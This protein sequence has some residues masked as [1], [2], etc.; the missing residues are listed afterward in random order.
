MRY[1]LLYIMC[2]FFPLLFVSCSDDADMEEYTPKAIAF[3][4]FMDRSEE[5]TRSVI[6]ED[7]SELINH[8]AGGNFWMKAYLRESSALYIDSRVWYNADYAAE[9]PDGNHWQF[10]EGDDQTGQI[11]NVYWPKDKVLDF[12]AYMPYNYEDYNK[13]DQNGEYTYKVTPGYDEQNHGV[14]IGYKMPK[15]FVEDDDHQEFIYAFTPDKSGATVSDGKINV[16]FVHPL[17]LIRFKLAKDS[18]R[19]KINN[20]SL[21]NVHTEGRFKS[22]QNTNEGMSGTWDLTPEDN[23]TPAKNTLIFNINKS[24]PYDINYNAV[25]GGPYMIL[26]QTIGDD[27]ELTIDADRIDE[28]NEDYIKSVPIKTDEV[29]E[30]EPGK[31]YTYSLRMG[32]GLSEILLDVEVEDWVINEYKNVIEV[33]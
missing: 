19:L 26:P 1:Y 11:Y 17:S 3:D 20:L 23:N 5:V 13:K 10:L 15:V 31:R 29:T 2:M 32:N 30:W 21:T 24:I 18:Y 27:M 12:F 7:Y 8:P 25:F 22:S 14:V 4:V 16:K 33:E 9:N 6:Y 28:T